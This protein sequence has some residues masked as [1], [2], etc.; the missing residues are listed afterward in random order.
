[1]WD[2]YQALTYNGKQ[3]RSTYVT[4]GDHKENKGPVGRSDRAPELQMEITEP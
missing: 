3:R 2:V 4:L 1:M